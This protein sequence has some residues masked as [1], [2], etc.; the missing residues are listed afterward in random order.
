M[1]S[2]ICGAWEVSLGV[3]RSRWTDLKG[4]IKLPSMLV[5]DGHHC[6]FLIVVFGSISILQRRTVPKVKIQQRI[7]FE[8]YDSLCS[9]MRK[10][11]Y[12]APGSTIVWCSPF[13]L[14][15]AIDPLPKR[16]PPYR[17]LNV[18]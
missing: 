9:A 13:A 2:G 10:L 15:L 16:Q 12:P 4:V 5:F 14:V 7:A 18:R 3:S 17:V 8:L 1:A 11:T 6:Y